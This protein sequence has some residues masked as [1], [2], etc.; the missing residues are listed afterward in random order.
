MK[1]RKRPPTSEVAVCDCPLK[2]VSVVFTDAQ[3]KALRLGW[4]ELY[5]APGAG[6]VRLPIMA[7]LVLNKP[8]N[9]GGYEFP[10]GA[11]DWPEISLRVGVFDENLILA[12][13]GYIPL[14]FSNGLDAFLNNTGATA[15][16]MAPAVHHDTEDASSP[17]IASAPANNL[18]NLVNKRLG[19]RLQGWPA[20]TDM[21]GGH[22]DNTLTVT[23][24]YQD[25]PVPAALPAIE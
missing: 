10:E 6:I 21:P 8:P 13:L 19:I 2:S 14:G 5:P 18:S 24:W 4:T 3:I 25:I 15:V 11:E 22:P 7:F 16:Y 12:T 20:E 17:F 23:V 9:G 1:S